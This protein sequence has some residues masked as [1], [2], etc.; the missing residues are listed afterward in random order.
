MQIPTRRLATFSLW[1]ALLSGLASPASAQ[2]ADL[3]V[4]RWLTRP[5][6]RFVA[7]EF[8]A[9]W[10]TPCM[11]AVPRWKKLHEKYRKKGLR[12]IVV[13]T[14]DPSGMC[15]NP[16]WNPDQMVCDVS[17]DLANAM[18][19]GDRLPSA[20]LWSWR[21]N[22]L[23]RKGHVGDVERE[24]QEAMRTLPRV[25]LR[26][27]GLEGTGRGKLGKQ[28]G[29]L[30]RSELSRTDKITVVAGKE[31][32]KLLDE[33]RRASQAP[34]AKDALACEV[35]QELPANSLLD[36]QLVASG[37][38][39]LLALSLLSA[40][41]SCLAAS[42][43][44]P[45]NPDK[46]ETTVAEAVAG[47]M[48]GLR[49]SPE[50]PGAPRASRPAPDPVAP[51]SAS[52]KD[53]WQPETT[54]RGLVRFV[55]EPGEAVVMLDGEMLCQ[56]TPCQK[57]VE[58]GYHRVAMHKERY[59]A[60]SS[61]VKLAAGGEV[62]W[63]LE[64]DFGTLAVTSEPPGL[65]VKLDSREV[66]Q[67]P[68]S[69]LEVAAGAHRLEVSGRC[70]YPE[71]RRV[72]VKRGKRDSAAFAPKERPAGL[73]VRAVDGDGNDLVADVSVD[74]AKVGRTPGVFKVSVC[75][76]KVEVRHAKHG[77]WSQELTLK[78]KKTASVVAK[79]G[80]GGGGGAA[81]GKAGLVWVKIPGGS[82]QM[83]S[84][85]GDADEKP[86]HRVTL[87]GFELTRS[88]VT[89]AQ[90]EACVKAGKCTDY[91]LT[92]YEWP[93]QD[94][95]EYPSC[96]WA[97]RGR[98]DHPINCVDWDQSAAFCQWAGGKLPTEAQWEYA[99]RSGGRDWRYPWGDEKATC[100]RAVMDD[101]GNG[102][103][104]GGTWPVCSKPRGHSKQGLCDLAGNVWEWVSDWQ[105]SY[106]PGSSRN[107]TGP[108][109]GSN[110][111]PRGGC[112]FNP[113]ARLRA[114]SRGGAPPGFRGYDLGFR[115]LR[116]HP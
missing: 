8:Y 52:A 46:P 7:V 32:R 58:P 49:R 91:H 72:T 31:E 102:C 16:G 99:A 110:R 104:K 37:S 47:L 76:R 95:T 62:S 23:V 44:A 55:S 113:A 89:V 116:S 6:V 12:L 90:Y 112:W 40:E 60:R 109:S 14:Q 10:C 86:V 115:C 57:V 61:S 82:F 11:E 98:G 111:V 65:T 18:G 100:D 66:G 54:A 2:D 13:S 9:T 56:A 85:E 74:G 79:L 97:K 5:G 78:E 114:A 48:D 68:L 92:G 22:L 67:T 88:E 21:G 51:P 42:A 101:G 4:E 94:F 105:G 34:S 50:M 3:D 70:H 27:E 83:G 29:A 41:T 87:D 1:L 69:A 43:V 80:A 26:T 96:N 20:F 77:E 15:R 73:D 107:P 28:I 25:A 81:A 19:V 108:S 59:V 38:R 24:L 71:E 36:V 33:I 35:G 39:K 63:T 45:W 93:G 106:S 84:N 30:L 17:G 53:D 64:P 103:G 75:A